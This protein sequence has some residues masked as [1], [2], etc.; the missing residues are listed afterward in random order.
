MSTV[1]EGSW[2]HD[3]VA[4]PGAIALLI[5]MTIS[6]AA[7]CHSC[8]DTMHVVFPYVLYYCESIMTNSI[9]YLLLPPSLPLRTTHYNHDCPRHFFFPRSALYCITLHS[10]TCH[11]SIDPFMNHHD[12]DDDDDDFFHDL[13]RWMPSLHDCWISW[14]RLLLPSHNTMFNHNHNHTQFNREGRHCI[15]EP[16]PTTCRRETTT[17]Y[18]QN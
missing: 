11:A 7:P 2:I 8:V 14:Q 18:R 4:G 6:G 17:M 15:L 9:R 12:D 1:V 3:D 5:I 13:M 10:I 16:D